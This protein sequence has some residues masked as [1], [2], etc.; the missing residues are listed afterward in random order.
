MKKLICAALI[1]VAPVANAEFWDGNK[2]QR[3]LSEPPGYNNGAAMGFIELLEALD[4]VA[5]NTHDDT[6]ERVARAAIAKA[7]GA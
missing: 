2:L 6:A 3:F 5:I 7:E 4:E 1:C